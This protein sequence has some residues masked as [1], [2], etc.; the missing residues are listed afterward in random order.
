[1]ILS[2]KPLGSLHLPIRQIPSPTIR[3]S[4]EQQ[5]LIVP[6]PSTVVGALAATL[7]ILLSSREND[8]GGLIELHSCLAKRF[9]GE[10]KIWGPLIKSVNREEYFIAVRGGLCPLH[11]L[12]RYAEQTREKYRGISYDWE[13]VVEKVWSLDK[14]GIKMVPEKGVA[15]E[16]YLYVNKYTA[17]STKSP[18]E[19]LYELYVAKPRVVKTVIRLGGEGRLVILKLEEGSLPIKEKGGKASTFVLLSPTILPSLTSPTP[20]SNIIVGKEGAKAKK[21]YGRV[22]IIGLGFSEALKKR[23]VAKPQL[24]PGTLIEFDGQEDSIT[25]FGELTELGY[26]SALGIQ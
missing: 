11:G 23:R 12:E 1:M 19:Y 20:V 3:I 25:W 5:A 15:E 21:V 7:D 22:E 13:G 14:I 24:L 18:I 8:L 2:I 17:A 9:G 26:G 16:G 4:Y 10:F 6:P